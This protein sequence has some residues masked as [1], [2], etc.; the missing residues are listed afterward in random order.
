M[1]FA[2]ELSVPST[3][4]AVY[5]YEAQEDDEISLT[6]GETISDVTVIDDGWA[7]GTKSSGKRGMFPR[8]YCEVSCSCRHSDLKMFN[9]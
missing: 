3:V 4:K 5:D 7:V 9:C 1:Y 8:N 6:D 2:V